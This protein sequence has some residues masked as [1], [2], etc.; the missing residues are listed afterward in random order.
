L[1][2]KE[3]KDRMGKKTKKG[4][5]REGGGKKFENFEARTEGKV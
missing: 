1:G 2:L 5:K 3:D 4:N